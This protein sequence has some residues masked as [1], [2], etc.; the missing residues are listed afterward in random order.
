[1][2]SRLP[3]RSNRPTQEDLP[4]APIASSFNHRRRPQTSATLGAHETGLEGIIDHRPIVNPSFALLPPQ[5]IFVWL[6]QH[7]G[8]DEAQSKSEL[9]GEGMDGSGKSVDGLKLKDVERCVNFGENPG[10]MR[11]LLRDEG[12]S[13]LE[14]LSAGRKNSQV[15]G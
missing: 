12:W 10:F 7:L 13:R 6:T 4:S 2:P 8:Y 9:M 5:E 1:M 11:C 3:T 15:Y 14:Y